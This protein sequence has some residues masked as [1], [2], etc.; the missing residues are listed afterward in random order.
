MSVTPLFVSSVQSLKA[1]LRLSGVTQDDTN[2]AITDTILEVRTLLYSRLGFFRIDQ[3]QA[4]VEVNA[5]TSQAQ[6]DRSRASLLETTWCRLLLLRRLPVL[7]QD[8]S[9]QSQMTWNE[10]GT[11]RRAGASDL[12]KEVQRLTE[13]IESLLAI[14]GNQEGSGGVQGG[15]INP[16][17]IPNL[18]GRSPY[19]PRK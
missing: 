19:L 6:L 12:E 17:I 4:T 10:E 3:I 1:S 7:F 8:A 11:T 15:V 14:L 13:E 5:P 2:K 16:S 18:L 9:A